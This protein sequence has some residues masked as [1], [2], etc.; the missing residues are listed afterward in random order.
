MY[1]VSMGHRLQTVE[2][3]GKYFRLIKSDEGN[4]KEEGESK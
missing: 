3:E 1:H 4:K 2:A